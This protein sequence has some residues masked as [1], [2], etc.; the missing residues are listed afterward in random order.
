MNEPSPDMGTQQNGADPIVQ[1]RRKRKRTKGET[2]RNQIL[3]ASS[4]AFHT[5]RYRNVTMRDI[6]RDVGIALGGLYFHF[7]S[8]DELIGALI[9]RASYLVLEQV[10]ASMAALPEAATSRE[11]L[12]AAVHAHIEATLH[13]G[14][15]SLTL[16]YLH[17]DSMVDVLPQSY[18]ALRNTHRAF[19]MDMIHSAQMDGSLRVDAPPM[20]MFFF[21]LGAIGWVP[22]CFD[23]RR[24]TPDRVAEYFTM[25]FFDGA[26]GSTEEKAPAR[27]TPLQR[28]K[29]Y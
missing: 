17:D 9:E 3:A 22:E 11:R 28:S 1:P 4:R 13:N 8:K 10:Q 25:F 27:A 18:A 19:W 26:G 2:S 15:Y 7:K 20:L 14:E 16:R 5:G 6:A 23:E 29:N 21:L 12:A 24:M